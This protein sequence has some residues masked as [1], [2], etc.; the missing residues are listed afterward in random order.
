MLHLKIKFCRLRR[1]LQSIHLNSLNNQQTMN[2]RLAATLLFSLF[3][4]SEAGTTLLDSSGKIQ[5]PIPRVSTSSGIVS[6]INSPGTPSILP[7]GDT[8]GSYLSLLEDEARPLLCCRGSTMNTSSAAERL[9]LCTTSLVSNVVIVDGITDGDLERGLRDSRHCRTL[10]ALF[11][12]RHFLDRESRQT[13]FVGLS[14]DEVTEDTTKKVTEEIDD[15]FRA[16]AEENPGEN[17]SFTDLYD[18]KIVAIQ[19]P[20]NAEEVLSEATK[21]AKSLAADNDT[22]DLLLATLISETYSKIQNSGVSTQALDSPAVA[23]GFL[24]CR[25]A[26]A[27]HAKAVRAKIASW[28]ARISRGLVVD[29]FGE[30]AEALLKRVLGGLDADTLAAS[31]LSIVSGYRLE[32]RTQLQ[33]LLESSLEEL[34]DDQVANLEKSTLKKFSRQL[35]NQQTS[36]MES[37]VDENAAA[38]RNAAFAFESGMDSLEIPSL[39]L[40]K[41]KYVREM[42]AKLSETLAKFP[43]SPE[44]KLKQLAAIKST[45]SKERKPTERSVDLGLDLVAMIRPDGFGS[46][47]GYAGYQMGGSSITVGIQ[48]DADDP[49]VLAQMG[50]VRPPLIRVQPKLRV[51]VEL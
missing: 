27:K 38:T 30:Q 8:D 50:G 41:D 42:S 26:Y 6:I 45:T 18:L 47:Q 28:K 24:S 31:G 7:D 1:H 17:I 25:E 2:L 46:L 49:Q 32:V 20:G 37:S 3:A 39:G 19:S 10:T 9:S 13:L 4:A 35:L 36:K 15:I 23:Q 21:T 43:D 34:F 48:N 44:S 14:I 51:D 33:A 40:I 16:V 11:R 29:G 5:H 22:G 12:A